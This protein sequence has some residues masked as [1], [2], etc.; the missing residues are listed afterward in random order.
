MIDTD[1]KVYLPKEVSDA[2]TNGG[3]M[4]AVQVISGVVNNV[5]PHVTK[6]ERVSGS[7]K[8]RKVFCKAADD[9]DGTLISPQYWIDD[10][11]PGDD[12]FVFFAGTLT[13]TQ[14]D[15]TGSERKYGVASL[16]TDAL[17]GSNTL[18]VE[19]EDESLANADIIFVTGDT[20][21]PTTKVNP[22]D[23]SGNEEFHEIDSVSV[24]GTEVTITIVGTLASDYTVAENARASSVYEPGDVAC[25]FDAPVVTTAGDGDVDASTY[26]PTLDNIGTIEQIITLT[27]S[28]ATNFV[29]TSNVAGVTLTSGQKGTEWSP[30]NSEFSKPYITLHANFFTGTWASGDTCVIHVYPAAIALWETRTVPIAAS[31]QSNNKI[32][33]VT[34]GEAA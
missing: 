19:V 21:R 13:N 6:A 7:K 5:W 16:K 2:G 31:P 34:A 32:T 24:S 26:A 28:D 18:V 9:S 11:T 27:F 14:A 30:T 22:D 23:I 17:A 20:I 4:S 12:W 10:V 1:L 3:R 25:S 15:I 29:A 8:H 33:L